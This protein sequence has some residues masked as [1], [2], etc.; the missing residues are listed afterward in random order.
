MISLEE[1]ASTY[2]DDMNAL[3]A[4]EDRYAPETTGTEKAPC[5]LD[6]EIAGLAKQGN[7]LK[8]QLNDLHNSERSF[9]A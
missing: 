5:A 9:S 2:N 3:S 4:F 8:N 7:S 6:E 1:S